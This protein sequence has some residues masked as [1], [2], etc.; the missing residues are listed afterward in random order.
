MNFRRRLSLWLLAPVVDELRFLR[1]TLRRGFL[2]MSDASNT[3]AAQVADLT[4]AV[5]SLEDE[6]GKDVAEIKAA[7]AEIADLTSQI[8]GATPSGLETLTGRINAQ[9][10][11]LKAAA[12][13]LP[14]PEPDPTP[15][16][17]AAAAAPPVEQIQ[18]V[19]VPVAD[20]A[21]VAADPAPVAQDSAAVAAGPVPVAQDPAR[22]QAAPVVDLP[23]APTP[24]AAVEL[25]PAS[26]AG[27]LT[28]AGA[29]AVVG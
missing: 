21:P 20:P 23:P 16:A 10:A 27:V 3:T 2:T 25:V 9:V 19:E 14:Q 5:T 29:A 1:S 22:V 26:P 8:A 18:A 6:V 7:V 13:A 24:V 28:P 15:S 11:K 4:A 17:P 12:D